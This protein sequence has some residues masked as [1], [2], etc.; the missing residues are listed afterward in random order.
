MTNS[1]RLLVTFFSVFFS[2]VVFGQ[3]FA[4]VAFPNPTSH[5]YY[6]YASLVQAS[7][8]TF[9]G[10]MAG[11]ASTMSTA[12][13]T[14][15]KMTA[16]GQVT[17]LA[18]FNT[19][20]GANPFGELAI[21]TDGN[22]YG[23]TQNGGSNGKG[24]V[25]KVTLTGTLTPLVHFNGAN[26]SQ[27]AAGLVRDVDGNFY[28]TTEFGGAGDYGTI[29]KVT[30]AGLLTTLVAF[31]GTNG[32]QPSCTLFRANDGN[33]Y[34][35]TKAGGANTTFDAGTGKWTGGGGTVFKITP[36]GVLTRIASFKNRNVFDTTKT[37]AATPMYGVTQGVDG[38]FYG[39][40]GY[41]GAYDRGTIFKATPAGQL[42]IIGVFNGTNGW[43]PKTLIR[44]NDGNFYGTTR[45]TMSASIGTV[46]RVTP[47]GLITKLVETSSAL[48]T[49]NMQCSGLMQASNGK[50]YGTAANF[51][52]SNP[53][54]GI[55]SLIFS[56]S[57]PMPQITSQPASQTVVAG[58][59]A[60]FAVGATSTTT[61]N[62]Q[63]QR[64]GTNI[65]GATT[66]RLSLPTVMTNAA[67]T[68][69]VLVRNMAGLV[70]SSNAV[71]KV[72][73]PPPPSA[74]TSVTA[75]ALSSQ[76]IAVR[77]TNTA[78]NVT[79]FVVW[80][81]SSPATTTLKVATVGAAVRG[82]TNIGL[83][84][85]TTYYYVVQATNA[86]GSSPKST[87]V[88]AK[89]FDV[90]P[91]APTALTATAAAPN[92]VNLTWKKNS[93]NVTSFSVSRSLSGG[94]YTTIATV[95]GSLTN[96]LDRSVHSGL[97]YAYMVKAVN[98]VGASTNSLP[99]SVT[100]PVG[101][102]DN[103]IFRSTNGQ[104]Q[105]WVM[106][107]T[108]YVRSLD[109]P[110]GPEDETGWRVVAFGDFD[111]D[112]TTDLVWQNVDGQLMTWLM[113]G[114][115]VNK[116]ETLAVTADPGWNVVSAADFNADGKTDLLWAN[117]NG[118]TSCWLMNGTNFVA[119]V[120]LPAGPDVSTG[121][122]I[123]GTADLNPSSTRDIIWQNTTG[124]T[125]VVLMEQTN[126]LNSVSL[127]TN[128]NAAGWKISSLLDLTADSKSD[129]V[130]E[131]ADG[132]IEA[133]VMNGTNYV[134]TVTLRTNTAAASGWNLIGPK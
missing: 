26:G 39:A 88:S 63:W 123:A 65:A 79:S 122:S 126:Y 119:S 97:N 37:N 81:G 61:L 91:T 131:K 29:F 25:F 103:L 129:F 11:T 113:N 58:S 109:L 112:F 77:W 13:G 49:T 124:M 7:D 14:V 110:T 107:A 130:W 78:T 114:T 35:T 111:G 45:R 41:G 133:W 67:G 85:A 72:I 22:L 31:K 19:N 48:V 128:A 64:S 34:G 104:L 92:R 75:N 68:Y 50:L 10:T 116:T 73:L 57:F 76:S 23:V 21:G 134:R 15:F 36:G 46:F 86:G 9:Y 12:A 59:T 30:P 95:S 115:N 24:T 99:A 117:T 28:G 32:M 62:Y 43:G 96:Y 51:F 94:A 70:T 74:P 3:T 53:L 106:N 108:N 5:G 33:F 127:R 55:S 121:W 83:A 93:T 44:G 4:P 125:S 60:N 101:L 40:T 17:L 38:N 54:E 87:T 66:S 69:R 1:L 105:A 52:R 8:G 71:L 47:Q 82:Y 42:T 56:L 89:T 18:K 84:R 2:G 120:A 102:A 6:P 132:R 118:Q 100:L 80:R 98:S 90:L 20:N 27:P 16:A